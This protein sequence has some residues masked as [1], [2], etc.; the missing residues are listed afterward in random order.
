MMYLFFFFED[1]DK[2]WLDRGGGISWEERS[3]K[4]TDY[5]KKIIETSVMHNIMEK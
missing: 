5:E 2:V 4:E 3:D 1:L